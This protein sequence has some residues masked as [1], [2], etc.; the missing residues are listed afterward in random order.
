MFDPKDF[1]AIL[2]KVIRADGGIK[3]AIL[4]DKTGL[5]ISHVSRFTYYASDADSI[6]VIASAVFCASEEQG[7]SLK[8]GGLGIVTSEFE[9]G[10]IFAVSTGRGVLCV[11]TDRGIN[12]GIIRLVMRKASTDLSKKLDNYLAAQG[13]GI[14]LSNESEFDAISGESSSL[15]VTHTTDSLNKDELEA[16]LRQL[17]KF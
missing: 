7:S 5:T 13:P 15:G 16:A 12:L 14:S 9:T 17:E 6:G 4:V 11:I 1:E 3:K 2:T 8:I 10:I